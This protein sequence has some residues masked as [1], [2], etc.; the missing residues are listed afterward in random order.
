MKN[1]FSI[2]ICTLNRPR[3]LRD[4]LESIVDQDRMPDEVI[5]VDS[6][7]DQR[8]AAV[9]ADFSGALPIRYFHTRQGLTY[10]RNFGIQRARGEIILFLD[11]DV[12][13]TREFVRQ[14]EGGFLL[15]RRVDGVGGLFTNIAR[16]SMASRFLRRIFMLPRVDGHGQMQKSGFVAHPWGAPEPKMQWVE[17]FCGA[18]AAFRREIF[19]EFSFD[20][21]YSGYGLGEDADFS[22]RVSLG[23][24]LLYNPEAK[25]YHRESEVNRINMEKFYYMKTYNHYYFFRKNLRP[26][27]VPWLMFWWSNLGVLIRSLITGLKAKTLGPIKGALRGNLT[28]IREGLAS[29]DQVTGF[30]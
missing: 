16:Q 25:I 3:D 2:I 24:R 28:I 17:V 30:K 26:Q 15:D 10:Q 18:A 13:L 14:I 27:K 8:S 29:R 7:V 22:Y 21:F 5:I 20:E 4:C 6:S 9:A 23:H 1:I 12:I 19:S 11:D